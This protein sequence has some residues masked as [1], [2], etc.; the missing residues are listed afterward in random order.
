MFMAL[1][2][3]P[4]QVILD[5]VQDVERTAKRE[6]LNQDCT[7]AD[8]LEEKIEFD[9]S[10]VKEKFI[11]SAIEWWNRKLTEYQNNPKEKRFKFC[12]DLSEALEYHL[13]EK[14]FQSYKKQLIEEA[15]TNEWEIAK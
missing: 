8:L 15:I 7:L 12:L 2:T 14:D 5:T 11:Q 4:K 1:E 3:L 13:T 10:E 9:L 6:R